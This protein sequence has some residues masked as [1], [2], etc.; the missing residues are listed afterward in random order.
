[1]TN[2]LTLASVVTTGQLIRSTDIMRSIVTFVQ[3]VDVQLI[4]KLALPMLAV[5]TLCGVA[6]IVSDVPYA[7]ARNVSR[8]LRE[9]LS[10][11][12]TFKPTRIAL[13]TSVVRCLNTLPK[14]Y[15][16]SFKP[17]SK[18][19]PGRRKSI[20]RLQ[21]KLV[22]LIDSLRDCIKKSLISTIW[23]TDVIC[24][25]IEFIERFSLVF[26]FTFLFDFCFYISFMFC[27]Y[28]LHFTVVNT[29]N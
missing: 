12:D 22:T 28:P 5:G 23:L 9:E 16:R 1:M 19:R 7:V 13:L 2:A 11:L 3:V 21:E 29:I 10:A 4:K 26:V 24:N 17:S 20:P 18:N 27:F 14:M 15:V 6:Y 25:V 8:K